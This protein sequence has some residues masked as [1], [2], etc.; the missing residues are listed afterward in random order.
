MA[1]E[2]ITLKS[3]VAADLRDPRLDTALFAFGP[4]AQQM[5]ERAAQK[6]E[7]SRVTVKLNQANNGIWRFLFLPTHCLSCFFTHYCLMAH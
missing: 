4:A 7:Q 5:E 1:S 2:Q 3:A 6:R